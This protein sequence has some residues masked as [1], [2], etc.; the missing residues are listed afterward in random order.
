MPAPSRSRPSFGLPFV[1]LCLLLASL[2]L[3]GGASRADALG[4]VLVRLAAAALL[5]VATLFGP[6]PASTRPVA[7][8][9]GAAVLLAMLHVVP[10]PPSVWQALPGRAALVQAA[11]LGG[12]P[13][14]WRPLAIVPGAALNAVL[15]LLIPVATLALTAMLNP[16]ERGRLPGV[17]LLAVL[18]MTPIGLL[19]V[20]GA[21]FDN[22][23]INDTLGDV[24]GLFAN[25]NHFAMFL[26]WG[27]LLAPA[28]ALTGRTGPGWRAPA[29]L[30]C[31]LLFEL[32]I[33]A[34]GSRA[35]MLL[36]ALALP[37]AVAMGWR[38][39]RGLRRHGPRWAFP[40]AITATVGLI[41]IVV[42]ASIVAGRAMS[43]DRI[44][45]GDVG[46]DM[47]VRGLPTVL[48]MAKAYFPIG[49][50]LGG[51]DPVFRMHEPFALLK[52]T[53]FNHAHNDV[54]EVVLTAGLP[55]AVLLAVALGWWAWASVR[56]WRGEA[57]LPR[58]GS[59]MLLFVVI[60]SL[61][62]YP[63]RT[64]LVMA[65]VVIAAVWLAKAQEDSKRSA[66]PKA[67]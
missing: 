14:P 23:L 61:F 57:A 11:V 66:L 17:L 22:P 24:N 56:A 47:R 26:A 5:L 8:L 28:W 27:C 3:A 1:L 67:R 29:A 35:G 18:A 52:P 50:G 46:D 55:G 7:C 16:E 6:R 49:T 44:A 51:F 19:Q 4:Q 13:Q 15:S 40:A 31:V 41:A 53:F 10:L 54:L 38:E 30:G 63:A 21:G 43:I 36:G 59:A 45:T 48:A 64:P 39:V 25:R 2:W 9:M 12:G 65:I 33:L 32:M 60:A 58:L 20:S 42:L 62:D 37:V 34:T